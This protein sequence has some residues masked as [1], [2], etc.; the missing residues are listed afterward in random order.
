MA[1]RAGRFGRCAKLRSEAPIRTSSVKLCVHS[2]KL[3]VE[4]IAV[5]L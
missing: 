3:C 1:L 4:L 2:V 5:L